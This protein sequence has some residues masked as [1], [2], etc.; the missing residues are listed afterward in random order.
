MTRPLKTKGRTFT[1]PKKP[2]QRPNGPKFDPSFIERIENYAH[3][4]LSEEEM[5]H[6]LGVSYKSFNQWKVKIPAVGEAIKRG[7][8][9]ATAHVARTMYLNA[10]GF[11]HDEEKIFCNAA[12]DVTRVMTTKK[13]PPNHVSGI[14]Y[15]KNKDPARW[16]DRQELAASDELKKLIGGWSQATERLSLSGDMIAS[17]TEKATAESQTT[18]H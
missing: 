13:Y 7:G 14:F 10:I 4:G 17:S 18:R 1:P 8:P 15:L 5:A 11:E 3:L 12:G 6:C 9:D 16:K 2:E